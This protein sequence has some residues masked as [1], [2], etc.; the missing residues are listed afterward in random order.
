M[1][2]SLLVSWIDLAVGGGVQDSSWVTLGGL[3]TS[4]GGLGSEAIQPNSSHK[5]EKNG[6]LP[7]PTAVPLCFFF[8]VC[9]LI[10]KVSL[11]ENRKPPNARQTSAKNP[12]KK[13]I[14]ENVLRVETRILDIL[15]Q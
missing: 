2:G 14:K 3:T 5:G 11:T 10:K 9:K 8:F 4:L 6:A 15:R 7:L 1:S 12:E 13:P